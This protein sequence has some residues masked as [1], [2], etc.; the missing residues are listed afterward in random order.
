MRRRGLRGDSRAA[1]QGAQVRR[2]GSSHGR[3]PGSPPL[4]DAAVRQAIRAVGGELLSHGAIPGARVYELVNET[5][6][7]P[8]VVRRV[9]TAGREFERG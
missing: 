7:D 4:E 8:V 9:L 6:V 2:G 5:D 1:L 3:G